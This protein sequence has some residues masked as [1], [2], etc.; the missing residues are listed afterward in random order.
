[1]LFHKQNLS[2]YVPGALLGSNHCNAAAV[3]C[4]PP[5]NPVFGRTWQGCCLQHSFTARRH[6]KS[7]IVLTH[8]EG[9]DRAAPQ[10]SSGLC[11]AT[12]ETTRRQLMHFS[13]SQETEVE[14]GGSWNPPCCFKGIMSNTQ[15]F[16][17]NKSFEFCSAKAELQLSQVLLFCGRDSQDASSFNHLLYIAAT[18]LGTYLIFDLTAPVKQTVT[19]SRLLLS[20]TKSSF[21]LSLAETPFLLH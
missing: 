12:C 10:N 18:N 11:A 3:A 5:A 6:A 19:P 1:M 20:I 14:K 8:V 7:M 13:H 21:L 9:L 15:V 16:C 2:R 4:R 17:C